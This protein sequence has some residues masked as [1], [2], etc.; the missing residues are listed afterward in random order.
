MRRLTRLAAG[1]AGR[2]EMEA[3]RSSAPAGAVFTRNS[4]SSV[5]AEQR[6][7]RGLTVAEP[8]C[9]RD[10]RRQRCV[11]RGAR[12]DEGTRASAAGGLRGGAPGSWGA[13]NSCRNRV[14]GH[15]GAGLGEYESVPKAEEYRISQEADDQRQDS[16][17]PP[18][19]AAGWA[20]ARKRSRRSERLRPPA[21]QGGAGNRPVRPGG[22]PRWGASTWAAASRGT[23]TEGGLT[24]FKPCRWIGI[25]YDEPL[26]KN[27][28]RNR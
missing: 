6:R 3:T 18:C 27:N 22:Q 11:W 2:G 7:R 5:R 25:R 28:G 10:R 24:D 19:S 20:H 13:G 4:L 9:K 12:A 16:V 23:V 1:P 21:P 14:T 15:G 8:Q 17:A 26:G